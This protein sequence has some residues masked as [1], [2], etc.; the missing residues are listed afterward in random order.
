MR[1]L[2]ILLG[3]VSL[4]IACED[5]VEVDLEEAKPR[6]VVD[7]ILQWEKG[8]SGE[9]QV[10]SLSRTRGFFEEEPRPVS[11]ALVKVSD[12]SGLEFTFEETSPGEYVTRNF[13][14]ALNEKYSLSIE[15]NGSVYS[16]EETLKPVVPIDFIQ[17]NDQG[18]F[19]SENIE[20]KVFY[21]DP[22]GIENYYLFKFF[23]PF[24]AFPEFDINEDEFSDGNQIFDI[25]SE[26][27]LEPGMPVTIQLHGISKGY[28]NFLEILLAQAG[29]AG[30]PFETQP[31][32]VRG[33]IKNENDTEEL[34]FG[35]FGLSEVDEII[36]TVQ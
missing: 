15:V 20:L 7:A 21:T 34:I 13:Q 14:P 18:G 17:Q 23:A 6:L 22:E 29:S 2:L 3:F 10:I 36:Y 1:K 4:F 24:L 9:T 26:E 19:S 8:T 31:A 16:A 5:V 28:Y 25:F 32:T 12:G 33:N 30:G 11:D 27:D 35:Y